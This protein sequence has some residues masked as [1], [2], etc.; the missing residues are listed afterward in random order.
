MLSPE[1]ALSS[2]E[3][4]CLMI[5]YEGGML[6]PVGRWE[7]AVKDLAEKGDLEKQDAFNYRISDRGKRAAEK[8]DA[9]DARAPVSLI[10]SSEPSM[11]AV[12]GLENLR[13]NLCKCAEMLAEVSKES[14]KL[15]GETIEQS[16]EKWAA[17][18]LIEA[19]RL[20]GN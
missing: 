11:Q 15:T 2:D 3:F 10:E 16:F 12:P 9:D 13:A 4:I 17:V 6:M 5:A 19:K 14:S 18:V 8:A 7:F 1:T 20:L